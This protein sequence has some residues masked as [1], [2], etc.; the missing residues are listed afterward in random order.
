MTVQTGIQAQDG[1]ETADIMIVDE[2]IVVHGTG[3]EAAAPALASVAM[4]ARIGIQRQD[5]AQAQVTIQGMTEVEDITIA[6]EASVGRGTM[7]TAA[8]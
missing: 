8:E 5:T 4:T 3:V 2:A 7:T 1:A 6:D